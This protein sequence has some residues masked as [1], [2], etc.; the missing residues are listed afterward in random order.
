M[1]CPAFYHSFTQLYTIT[2]FTHTG[3]W[4][5]GAAVRCSAVV[6]STWT[7]INVHT[8]SY[9]SCESTCTWAF[10]GARCVHTRR[11][12]RTRPNCAH[13]HPKWSNF[14][15]LLFLAEVA[16]SHESQATLL[17]KAATCVIKADVIESYIRALQASRASP[18]GW[19]FNLMTREANKR[20]IIFPLID[21]S[22]QVGA[23]ES[24]DWQWV[25]Y[26]VWESIVHCLCLRTSHTW[27]QNVHA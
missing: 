17:T 27:W 11:T 8:I 19:D 3:T 9:R 1:A 6:Q 5:I 10:V 18:I 14:F 26:H 24:E 2:Y 16:V 13:K 21:H 7:F 25:I 22:L 20:D 23:G 4:W 15:L 12:V